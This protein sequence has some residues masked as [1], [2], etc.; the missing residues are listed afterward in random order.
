MGGVELWE[1]LKCGD[2][3]MIPPSQDAPRPMTASRRPGNVHQYATNLDN[4]LHIPPLGSPRPEY[5]ETVQQTSVRLCACVL[6][7]VHLNMW[8]CSIIKSSFLTTSHL[9]LD[10]PSA[11]S[12][13]II[14]C[15][16]FNN[17]AFLFQCRSQNLGRRAFPPN[18]TP[19][20]A[21]HLD[22]C[23]VPIS[24]TLAQEHGSSPSCPSVQSCIAQE[25]V[26]RELEEDLL[27]QFP[28][29]VPVGSRMVFR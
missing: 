4:P 14:C 28:H 8:D 21:V 3:L 11:P 29:G 16:T 24:R 27:R 7:C 10:L 9:D 22:P 18:S 13:E 19:S 1:A 17:H 12:Y 2:E 23:L 5:G 26:R 25:G 15:N 20:V 6:V